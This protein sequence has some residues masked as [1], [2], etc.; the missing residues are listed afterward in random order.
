M[1]KTI[2]RTQEVKVGWSSFPLPRVAYALKQI[3][4]NSKEHQESEKSQPQ[5]Y[6]PEKMKMV[7]AYPASILR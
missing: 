4:N 5:G 2:T 1:N 3:K 7:A 6:P